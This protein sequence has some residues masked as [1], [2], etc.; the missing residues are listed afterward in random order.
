MQSGQGTVWLPKE[1][2]EVKKLPDHWDPVGQ[3]GVVPWGS[4]EV[5]ELFFSGSRQNWL[6]RSHHLG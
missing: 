3:A 5:R 1:D 2:S 6:C 4:W